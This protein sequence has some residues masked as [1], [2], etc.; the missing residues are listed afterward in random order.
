MDR[1]QFVVPVRIVA[2]PGQP[3][4]EIYDVEEAL[5]FL[6]N[7][8][9]G[10]QGPVYQTALNGCSAAIADQ[11]S[12]EDARTSF[13]SFA[14]ITKILAKD[15]FEKIAINIDGEMLPLPPKY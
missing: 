1:L 6:E 2:E 7:W 12:V 13:V 14:R 8:P 11:M 5:A 10:R 15:A 9:G 3:V 4:T